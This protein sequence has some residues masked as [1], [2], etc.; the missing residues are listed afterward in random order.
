MSPM[1][2]RVVA[3]LVYALFLVVILAMC[4]I[5]RLAGVGDS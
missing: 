1:A 2:S 3:A 5:A 4:V